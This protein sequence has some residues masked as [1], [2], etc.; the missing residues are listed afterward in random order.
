[1]KSQKGSS[2]IPPTIDHDLA[3]LK[4]G[5]ADTGGEIKKLSDDSEGAKKMMTLLSKLIKA[6]KKDISKLKVIYIYILLYFLLLA[7]SLNWLS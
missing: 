2:G 4:K 5:M 6:V 1:M 7:T 3:L